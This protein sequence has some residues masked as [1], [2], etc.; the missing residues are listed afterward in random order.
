MYSSADM[1][2]DLV[3][4]EWVCPLT[5]D[6]KAPLHDILRWEWDQITV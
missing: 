6:F 1:V 4:S 5:V 3:W 2:P